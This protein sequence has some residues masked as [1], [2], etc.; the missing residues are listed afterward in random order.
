MDQQGNEYTL[1]S[2]AKLYAS[3]APWA[4]IKALHDALLDEIRGKGVGELDLVALQK[5]YEG[6]NPEG[7]NHLVDK[8]MGLLAS[9]PI[10]EAVFKCA[11]KALYRPDGEESSVRVTRAL[12]DDPKLRER[13]REDYYAICLGV[14]G[15]NL[16]PFVKALF[17]ALKARAGKRAD[18]Q[19]PSAASA[20]PS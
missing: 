2:G 13:V 4:D 8:M 7:F 3:V 20:T 16:R 19:G 6:G 5:A 18:I 14:G 15:V 11:E 9:K 12:F 17:S 10:E 1:P